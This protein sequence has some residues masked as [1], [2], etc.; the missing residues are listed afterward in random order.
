VIRVF[1][2]AA[3]PLARAALQNR[4]K[5]PGVKFVGS[6]AAIDALSG[7]VSDTQADVLLVDA[8]GESPEAIMESLTESGLAADIPIVVLI[9]AASAAASAQGL[10]AGIRAV[11]PDSAACIPPRF[12]LPTQPPRQPRS[13]LPSFPNRSPAA[14][15]KSC[16]C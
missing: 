6:A 1:L 5:G 11:L 8:D 12:P 4:F 7:D 14:S 9:E 3:S 2:I 16:K 13:I 15:A 10:Q